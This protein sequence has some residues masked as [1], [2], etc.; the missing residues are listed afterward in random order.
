MKSREAPSAWKK[1]IV[2]A[3]LVIGLLVTSLVVR[4]LV[5]KP[6]RAQAEPP[7]RA[8]P[9]AAAPAQGTAAVSSATDQ[10]RSAACR[11]RG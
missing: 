10:I 3:S 1:R 2:L 8:R 4:Q 7:P 5:M 9:Q 11:G 6:D